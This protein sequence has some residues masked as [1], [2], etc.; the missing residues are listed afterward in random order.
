M[1][2]A[3]AGAFKRAVPD[4][5]PPSRKLIDNVWKEEEGKSLCERERERERGGDASRYLRQ[6]LPFVMRG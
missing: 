5:F 1:T 4:V 3:D 2:W 6:G